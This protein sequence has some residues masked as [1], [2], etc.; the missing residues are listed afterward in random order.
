MQTLCKRPF[1]GQGVGV[2]GR[3]G[4]GCGCGWLVGMGECIGLFVGEKGERWGKVQCNAVRG[5]S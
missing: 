4:W 5:L 1:G 3:W 2:G